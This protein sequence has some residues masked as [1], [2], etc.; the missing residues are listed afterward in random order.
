MNSNVL[1]VFGEDIQETF[2][3]MNY[4][5]V[6][7]EFTVALNNYLIELNDEMI[8]YDDA[9]MEK[10]SHEK[11]SELIQSDDVVNNAHSSSNRYDKIISQKLSSE[12]LNQIHGSKSIKIYK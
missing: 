4:K 3:L 2:C 11:T 6:P 12:Y 10:L 5:L 1:N 7:L 9:K 8:E